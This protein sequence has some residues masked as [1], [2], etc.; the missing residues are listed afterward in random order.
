[1]SNVQELID[2]LV[3]ERPRLESAPLKE[4]ICQV[5]FPRQLSLDDDVVRPI[6]RVLSRRYP[7]LVEGQG[8]KAVEDGPGAYFS[9]ADVGQRTFRFRDAGGSWTATIGPEAI[10]LETTDYVGMKDLLLRWSE[11][12]TAAGEALEL[13]AQTRLGLRYINKLD[14]FDASQENLSSWVREELVTLLKAQPRER[15]LSFFISHSQFREPDGLS[16]HMRHGFAPK[17]DSEDRAIFL[18]DLDCYRGETAKFDPVDQI[19]SLA[20]LND[21]AYGYFTWAFRDESLKRF[22]HTHAEQGNGA[23]LKSTED[24][25]ARRRASEDLLHSAFLLDWDAT[26]ATG[27]ADLRRNFLLD[28]GLGQVGSTEEEREN[29]EDSGPAAR[30]LSAVLKSLRES[31]DIPVADLARMVGLRRRQFYNLLAG[32]STSADTESRIRQLA[33]EI[34]RLATVTEEGPQAMRSAVLAPVGPEA[35]SLFEVAVMGD[36]VRLRDTVDRLLVQVET[37]GVR[38]TRRAI[39]RPVPPEVAR[40]RRRLMRE[41]LADRPPSSERKES[42]E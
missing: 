42:G 11:L 36:R 27:R 4:V 40:R 3:D 19:R 2:R 12:V 31:I 34:E 24:R 10:A 18:L 22:S 21:C 20:R 23:W 5:Q 29:F 13:T 6:Q 17:E 35:V 9:P 25:P 41:S 14:F 7:M 37:R 30:P 15:H 28:A 16:C 38:R 8:V 1:M 33:V 26:R 32:D 39:P